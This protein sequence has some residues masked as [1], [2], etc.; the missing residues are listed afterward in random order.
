MTS[1]P[2]NTGRAESRNVAATTD[3]VRGE[4]ERILSSQTFRYA[5][6]QKRFL[7]HV[8]QEVLAGRGGLLKEYSIG[9]EVLGKGEQFDPRL[10]AIVRLEARK[11]RRNLQK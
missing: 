7:A 5:V 4:L 11:I 10:N 8:V 2:L 6:S 3:A 1:G 9:V